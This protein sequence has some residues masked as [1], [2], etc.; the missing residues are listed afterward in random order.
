MH[1]LLWF[2]TL[3]VTH[4]AVCDLSVAETDTRSA[5]VE[6]VQPKRLVVST[7]AMLCHHSLC[8]VK[9]GFFVSSI[10]LSSESRLC[11]ASLVL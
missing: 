11:I 5:M 10:S 9:S 2:S 8:D 7:Q 3:E 6:M 4:I 1:Y